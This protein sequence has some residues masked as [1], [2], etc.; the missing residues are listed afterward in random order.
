MYSCAPKYILTASSVAR[1]YGEQIAH[2]FVVP[3][4][5]MIDAGSKV[6][7]ESGTYGNV[8]EGLETFLTRKDNNGKVWGPQEQL[9]RPTVLKM[10]TQWAA[11]YVLKGDKLGSIEPGKLADLLV[12]DKDYLRIPVEQVGE[13]RPQVTISDGRIV[14]VHTDFAAEYNLRPRGAVISTFQ[15]LTA[16]RPETVRAGE[17]LR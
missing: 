6:A 15:E 12:L 8:W 14:F 10:A 2:T 4:K 17:G 7:Y 3:V 13:I 16:R 9:D 1:G 11:D 5:S